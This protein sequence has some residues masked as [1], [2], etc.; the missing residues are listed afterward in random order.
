MA[1]APSFEATKAQKEEVR[2]HIL[3]R[4]DPRP[5][6]GFPNSDFFSWTFYL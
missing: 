2:S 4:T 3:A 1:A 5:G 6:H